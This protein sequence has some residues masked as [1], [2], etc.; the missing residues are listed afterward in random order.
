MNSPSTVSGQTQDGMGNISGSSPE[1][2]KRYN[3]EKRILSVSSF[4]L[5]V[6]LLLALLFFN[7]SSQIRK[8]CLNISS[9]HWMVVLLYFILIGIIAEVLSLPFGF[10]SGFVLEH[11]YKLSNQSFAEWVLDE[12]KGIG[13]G[14]FLGIFLGEILYFLLREYPPNWWIIGGIF[15]SL[16]TV[17]MAN[18][19]PVLLMPIFF[20]FKPM[21]DDDLKNRLLALA[22]KGRT[23]IKGVYEMD[24]SRK[25]RT[26]NAALTGLGNTRRIIVSDTMLKNYTKDEIEVVLAHELGHHLGNHLLKGIIFKA[27]LIFLSFFTVDLALKR[28]VI[29]FGYYGISDVA[30]FPLLIL[31]MMGVSLIALPASNSFT[32]RLE[33]F[34][35]RKAIELTS[36]TESFIS[37]MEKLAI[38]NLADKDPNPVI[39]FIFFSHPSIKKRIEFAR[40]F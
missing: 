13:V 7:F 11:R 2:V 38:Q 26:A 16:F 39:E 3:L 17:I 40:N 31:V 25:S 20:N 28:W 1:S 24:L 21:D 5:E 10:Y 4:I 35:D 15:F 22:A 37:A 29:Y 34:A 19:A 9:S 8:F 27:V 33:K 23:K 18:L 6:I 32:R 36:N 30:S 12:L 14:A